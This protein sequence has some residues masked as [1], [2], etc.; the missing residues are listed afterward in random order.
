MLPALR[1]LERSTPKVFESY[2]TAAAMPRY[3]RLAPNL[4]AAS[5]PLMKILPA[6]ALVNAAPPGVPIADTSSGTMALSLKLVCAERR[7]ETTFVTPVLPDDLRMHLHALGRTHIVEVDGNQVARLKVLKD[8]LR[9]NP[10]LHWTRQYE[11][12]LVVASYAPVGFDLAAL[13][14]DVLAATYGSGGS[15][16]GIIRAL[17]RVQPKAIM[18]AID[19]MNSVLFGRR[20][21]PRLVSGIGNSLR[22][23][24]LDHAAVDEVVWASD[25]F[26]TSAA[27][28]IAR[29][30]GHLLGPTGAIALLVGRH[31]ACRYPNKTVACVLPDEGQ[32]YLRSVYAP[33]KALA[34]IDSAV[35]DRFARGGCLAANEAT[36]IASHWG[37]S[38]T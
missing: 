13:G 24:V 36:I 15:G 32:R 20:D 14:A 9:D 21:G 35:L 8:V 19:A 5:F 18:V 26:M 37:R 6:T 16:T 22:P 17:R 33:S 29:N 34:A 28:H 30:E 38:A 7:I 23:A 27:L 31:Y 10:G 11:S 2:S 25:L 4:I 1:E 3:L 12:E